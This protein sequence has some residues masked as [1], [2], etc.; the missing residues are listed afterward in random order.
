M[1]HESMRNILCWM[2]FIDHLIGGFWNQ[3]LPAISLRK[4]KYSAYAEVDFELPSNP[5]RG[6]RADERTRVAAGGETGL[7]QY[8]RG[9]K[10]HIGAAGG[11]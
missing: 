8:F 2:A 1:A 5:R 3:K 10:S 11:T 4:G 7:T 6:A 9:S